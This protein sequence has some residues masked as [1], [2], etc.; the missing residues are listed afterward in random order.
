MLHFS[1]AD[2]GDLAWSF[3]NDEKLHEVSESILFRLSDTEAVITRAR[4]LITSKNE[5]YRKFAYRL[6]NVYF[7]N[8]IEEL[9]SIQI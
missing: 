7:R 8:H 5:H 6:L 3:L 2:S 4:E 9:D 1:T